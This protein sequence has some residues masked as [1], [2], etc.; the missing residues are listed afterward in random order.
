MVITGILG[1]VAGI[2]GFIPLV[3]S[4]HLTKRV[5][6][7]SNISHAGA[8]LSG[9]LLSFLILAGS[10]IACIF[11]ARDNVLCFVLSEALALVVTA[12]VYGFYKYA[13]KN[14]ER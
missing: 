14:R 5:T 6:T 4:L 11:I 10:M 3:Y 8:L 9:V 7:T 1:V 12:I 2:L 13:G